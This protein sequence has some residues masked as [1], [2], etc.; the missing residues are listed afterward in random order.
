[1]LIGTLAVVVVTG[2]W[3]ASWGRAADRIYWTN[4]IGGRLSFANLNGSG[5]GDLN[6]SGATPLVIPRG[7]TI[8]AA[9]GRIYWANYGVNR[10]SFANLDG[11][12][13]GGDLNIAGASG[14]G[15]FGVAIDPAGGRIYW[16]RS[17]PSPGGISFANLNGS[18][19]GNLNTSGA[20]VSSPAGVAIDPAAGRIYW[21]NNGPS[22]KISF[23]NLNGSGGG[24]LN[25]SGA[26]VAFPIGVAID[27]A[28]GRIYWA[29][30]SPVTPTISFANLG[31]SGGGNL[32][33]TGAT[34]NGPAGVAIDPAAGR[35]Y[36]A[37]NGPSNKISFAN[38]NGSGGGDLNTSGATVSGPV[39]P[40]LLEAPSGAGAPT[41]AGGSRP[42][43]TLTCSRGSWASD[44]LGSLLYRAPQSFS[45]AWSN[46]GSDIAGAGASIYKPTAVGN[47]RC[48]VTA[49]NQ[50]GP[51]SQTS[52]LHTVF[53]LGKLT[54]NKRK[55]T[56][57]L[58]VIV[59]SRGRLV[60]KGKGV[61]KQRPA[62]AA[63]ASKTVTSAGTV[64]LRI[65]AKG[66]KKR[67]LDR[68]GKVKV[69]LMVKFQPQGGPQGTQVK[70]V[71]LLE[72]R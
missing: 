25:T 16:A 26:T 51:T 36:W 48:R 23:A 55:G 30:D 68:R 65:K 28:A 57:T 52:S 1:V 4:D 9:S 42:R 66:K 37:N 18:G 72:I 64:K 41:V 53:R 40:A 63:E 31:G 54:R 14:S 67:I 8:D 35:I 39:L 38:L 7:V 29:N 24:D 61:V 27:P 47:Y 33:T 17:S 19:G 50:A 12:G 69:K 15:P 62:R 56:A 13:G 3:L 22:N 21:A 70:K 46:K 44:L 59:P 45:Y 20:A 34:V 43:S 71:R 60:L 5:G 11:S 58:A 49:S 2:A 10:V 32:N 6:T